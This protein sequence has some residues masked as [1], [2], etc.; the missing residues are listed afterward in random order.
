MPADTST[1]YL[2]AGGFPKRKPESP[3]KIKKSGVQPV[4]RKRDKCE[5]RSASPEREEPVNERNEFRP[6]DK[7]GRKD[8]VNDSNQSRK[9]DKPDKCA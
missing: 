3:A 1:K 6:A 5:D 7:L 9:A 2:T 8:R 4:R